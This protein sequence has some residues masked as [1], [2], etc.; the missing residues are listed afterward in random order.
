[1]GIR[2]MNGMITWFARNSVAANLLM[3]GIVA[4]GLSALSTRILV[5]VFPSFERDVVTIMV[6][7]PGASPAEVESSIVM[8]V[9]EAISDLQGVKKIS[10][11]AKESLAQT[12]V[13]I[14]GV[15]RVK[16]LS[17]IQ[18]RIDGISTFPESAE[19][20]TIAVQE[21]KRE[22]ISLVLS[23]DL[24][25]KQLH[26]LAV[27][28]R[29]EVTHLPYITQAEVTG[30]RP[31]EISIEIP[32]AT[33]QRYALT[34][35]KVAQ[36][37]RSASRDIP[38]GTLK[39]ESGEL[40]LRVLGQAY[41]QYDFENIVITSANDGTRIRLGDI[42]IVHDAFNEAPLYADFDGKRSAVIPV[43][44]SN[45]QSVLKQ[46]E[47]VKHYIEERNLTLPPNVSLN[48]WRDRSKSIKARLNTLL[49]SAMQGGVLIM[50]LLALFL[51]PAI[52]L[53]VSVGI[54]ISFMGALA[55]MPEMGV[56]INLISLFA[57]ILVLGIVVD[58]AIVTGENIYSHQKLGKSPLEAAIEGTKEVAVPVTF[59][60]LTT[61][62]A[63]TPLLMLGGIR[64]KIFAFIPAIVIPVLLFSLIESKLILPTHLSHL[65]PLP[66]DKH[67]NPLLRLQQA[68]ANTLERFIKGV[69]R[70]VLNTILKLR[71]FTLTFFTSLLILSIIL[72]TTGHFRFTFMPRVQSEYIKATLYMPAGTADHITKAYIEHI[73]KQAEQLKQKYIDPE[74]NKSIIQHILVTTGSTGRGLKKTAGGLSHLGQ[75]QL[76]TIP[77][78]QRS[79]RITSSELTR[80]WRKS[81]GEIPGVQELKFRSEIAHG[82][83][84]IDI[85]L[86]GQD[87]TQ[88]AQAAEAVK[89]RIKAEYS[90]KGVFG[91]KNSFEGGKDEVQISLKP[92]ADLLGLNLSD[93]GIQI[94]HAFYGAEAERI[95]RDRDEIKV[96]VRY[97]QEERQRFSDLEGMIIHNKAGDQIPLAEVADLKTEKGY[98]VITREEGQRVVNI[99]ADLN[100]QKGNAQ[101]IIKD[102]K[103][104][105]P[106]VLSA[107]PEVKSSLE[108]EQREQQE[109]MHSF[110]VGLIFV[111]FAI[112]A[113]LAIPFRSYIQPL[114][115]M[116]II[117]FGVIGALIGHGIMGMSVSISSLLGLLALTGV[118][119]NDS[120]V[121]VDYINRRRREGM[122][123]D[124]AVRLAGQK[125]FR[126]ILLTSLTTFFGL[127][128]LIMEESTQA[129]F[130]IP[131]AVS[132]GF[133]ILFATFITLLLIPA[134]Y[135]V[136]EDI[137][138]FI[139]KF[140]QQIRRLIS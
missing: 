62:V 49:N 105:L 64:G 59:G 50:L 77:P 18:N 106:E 58:D 117:P 94:R 80:E 81:I 131:M 140:L 30:L 60:I 28:I 134:F 44:R 108:G 82:G 87:F 103:T 139:N 11:S 74:T 3:I 20:P 69:Y 43:Y 56:S 71:Y 65:K 110:N 7:Y 92:N 125:R 128:P 124:E 53:W 4:L 75:I 29:D 107:Y 68:I 97:P 21:R 37:I 2:K 19:E 98:P 12:T 70:P 41:R 114:I 119:I 9:E 52:A 16:M 45:K 96:M 38:A 13:E 25:E 99:T 95:Q 39:A 130:L 67:G 135:L 66:N 138:R 14:S 35:D 83:A 101:T 47:I 6:S 85:Q 126:P 136:F 121:M 137:G 31:Y 116:S 123:L 127:M 102:I 89:A 63:F 111:L 78:E 122:P 93:L 40:R 90:D 133:G 24:S 113:L 26:K 54:P 10:S 120:L 132:L 32:Q 23:G 15:N 5:E 76:E 42:A 55:L 115:V 33:L 88:L 129:Q 34:L 46:V 112:Y 73:T 22:S 36:T 51:R 91:I 1:M 79:L 109:M 118:V 27:E 84:P 104:W 100:K 8:Q 72:V 86:E 61:I 17:D 48:Y 57:F